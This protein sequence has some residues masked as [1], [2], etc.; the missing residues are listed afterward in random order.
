MLKWICSQ[1]FWGLASCNEKYGWT[2]GHSWTHGWCSQ[3]EKPR[4]SRNFQP[5]FFCTRG[6]P[7]G[8]SSRIQFYPILCPPFFSLFSIAKSWRCP[9]F[10]SDPQENHPCI[11]GIWHEFNQSTQLSSGNKIP[12]LFHW[13]LVGFF[14]DSPFVDYGNPQYMKGTIIP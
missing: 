6:I 11:D 1:S 4:R 13:I 5:R 2:P 14:R 10:V 7:K 8:I 9:N 12:L 3:R